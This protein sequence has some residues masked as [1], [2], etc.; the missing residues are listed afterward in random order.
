[1]TSVI[2]APQFPDGLEWLNVPQALTI[3]DLRGRFVILDFW[4]YG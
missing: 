3:A 2:A 1:M 4:T